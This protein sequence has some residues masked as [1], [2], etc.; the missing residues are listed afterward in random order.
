MMAE[1]YFRPAHNEAQL[2]RGC[3]PN[4]FD[5]AIVPAS[6]L[7]GDPD[8][9]GREGDPW[10]LAAALKARG[11]PWVVDLGTPQ[12]GHDKVGTAESCRRLRATEFARVLPLP[13][14]TKRLEDENARNAFVDA[15]LAFQ[16]GV[17]MLA[18]PYLEIDVDGDPCAHINSVMLRR[19]VGAAGDRLAVGF[20]QL[21]LRAL[22]AGVAVR[23]AQRY[24]ETKVTRVFLRVRNLR[25]ESATTTQL[26]NYLAAVDAFRGANI[27]V[28]CDP[29][30][31]FGGAAVAA[32]AVGFSAGSQFFR[33][34]PRRVVAAGGGGGGP[35]L[36]VEL[37]DYTALPRDLLAGR[38]DCPVAGCAVAA[39]DLSLG[40][41]KEHNLHY[42]RH[43]GENARDLGAVIAELRASAQPAA[44]AWAD[45]LERRQRKSA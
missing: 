30:G 38:L 18:A 31:R 20:V 15:A 1:F 9:E 22:N 33:S 8:D 42:M 13:L 3:A 29:A 23:I 2:I 28:V 36:A 32:G 43:L 35:K 10:G 45:V 40:A 4:A 14:D 26:G 5:G 19:V 44:L 6:Y 12:L 24:A 41:L 34:V 17:P 39:G 21:T 37:S 11:V 27:G 16:A 25:L 7:V